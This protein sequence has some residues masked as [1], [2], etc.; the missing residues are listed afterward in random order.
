[1]FCVTKPTLQLSLIYCCLHVENSHPTL[2]FAGADDSV[3]L[4]WPTIH[5]N[6]RTFWCIGLQFVRTCM[7]WTKFDPANDQIQLLV[8]RAMG[9]FVQISCVIQLLSFLM[10][11]SAH[12][13]QTVGWSVDIKISIEHSICGYIYVQLYLA[14]G[15]AQCIKTHICCWMTTGGFRLHQIRIPGLLQ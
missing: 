5:Q 8:L 3:L 12:R 11:C 2:R 14:N 1:M 4:Y 9:K 15:L 13:C 6:L 10:W 7:C